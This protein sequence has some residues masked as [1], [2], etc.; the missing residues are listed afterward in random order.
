MRRRR[1]SILNHYQLKLFRLD[2]KLNDVGM[3]LI[4]TVLNQQIQKPTAN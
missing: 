3:L 2:F 1:H 4:A